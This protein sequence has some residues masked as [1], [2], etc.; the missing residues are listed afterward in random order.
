MTFNVPFC[1]NPVVIL[2]PN[3]LDLF[4]KSERYCVDGEFFFIT[5]EERYYAMSGDN[6]TLRQAL[7]WPHET[8]IQM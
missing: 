8:I 7:Q 3:L 6:L 1:E 5:S 4:L 2:N